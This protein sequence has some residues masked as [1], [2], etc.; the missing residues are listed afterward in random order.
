MMTEREK[1][2]IN[3]NIKFLCKRKIIII[4]GVDPTITTKGLKMTETSGKAG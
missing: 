4:N 2:K 3:Y 1:E